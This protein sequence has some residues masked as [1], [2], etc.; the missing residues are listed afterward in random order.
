MSG[1]LL[2]ESPP[3]VALIRLSLTEGIYTIPVSPYT[4]SFAANGS[5]STHHDSSAHG[6]GRRLEKLVG[7][8]VT[9]EGAPP[10]D[11]Y[12]SPISYE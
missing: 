4:A 1:A 10:G 11:Q 8:E 9:H 7:M 3:H 12:A 6:P 2:F 5:T